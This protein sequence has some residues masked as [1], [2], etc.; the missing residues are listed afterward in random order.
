[1]RTMQVFSDCIFAQPR[2]CWLRRNIVTRNNWNDKYLKRI[3]TIF[4]W[5][6]HRHTVG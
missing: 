5:N 1:M 3:L 6:M 2:P 4:L